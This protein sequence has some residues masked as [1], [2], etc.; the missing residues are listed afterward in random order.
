MIL[1]AQRAREAAHWLVH[2]PP[3]HPF[4]P[5]DYRPTEHWSPEH[6]ALSAW[7]GVEIHSRLG[8]TAERLMERFIQLAPQLTLL[9]RNRVIR[10]EKRTL[11]EMDLL[12]E[13]PSGLEHWEL[14]VKFYAYDPKPQL[15]FGSNTR[16]RLDLKVRRLLNHQLLLSSHPLVLETLPSPPLARGIMKGWLFY[17]MDESPSSKPQQERGD[18]CTE[19]RFLE[20]RDQLE[21]KGVR[22]DALDKTQWLMLKVDHGNGQ[23]TRGL[24]QITHPNGSTERWMVLDDDWAQRA[25]ESLN[26]EPS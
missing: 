16:D 17:P 15:Y 23:S 10:D 9:D 8:V 24:W 6:E 1:E 14:S 3:L 26:Q 5:L 22:F 19:S 7:D 18:W 25:M 13:T 2:S 21:K 11:G 12:L 4:A 20:R